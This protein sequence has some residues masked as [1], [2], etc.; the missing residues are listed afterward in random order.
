MQR[1]GGGGGS[2]ISGFRKHVDVYLCPHLL[3]LQDTASGLAT[4]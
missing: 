4:P 3:D 1:R 2:G